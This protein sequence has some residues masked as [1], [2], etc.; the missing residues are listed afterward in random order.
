MDVHIQ[1]EVF[2]LCVYILC[3]KNVFRLGLVHQLL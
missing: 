1:I 3:V 2:S